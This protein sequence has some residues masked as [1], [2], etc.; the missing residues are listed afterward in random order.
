MA[1][2]EPVKYRRKL[3]ALAQWG[4]T[5]YPK[6][7]LDSSGTVGPWGRW[8]YV[9]GP[10]RLA[11]RCDATTVVTTLRA[12]DGVRRSWD[13]PREALRWLGEQRFRPPGEGPPFKGGWVGWLGYDAGRLF[14][15]MPA[16][17]PDPLG[18]P[19]FEFTFHSELV[20]ADHAEQ[21]AWRIQGNDPYDAPHMQEGATAHPSRDLGPAGQV[22][23]AF[24]RTFSREAYERAVARTVEYVRAGDVFQ[25][26]LSQRF[27]VGTRL[28]AADL[29]AASL[30][31][32]NAWYG[33][34]VGHRDYALVSL[35]PEL[36]FRVTPD[37]A[38]G[39]RTVVTRPIKG[40]RP[41][42]PGMR[43]A[44]AASTKDAAELNM[45]VDLERNDLGRVCRVGTVKVVE[46]RHVERHPTVY[47]GVAG[48][49]G[50]L[51][52]DVTFLDLLRATFPGGSV[53]GAPKIRAMQ[54]ID[55]LEPV[56]RG[57][58]CGAIGYLS[59]DG[60]VQFS[61]AIRTMIVKDGT[62]HLPVGGG[63]VADSQPAAEYEETLVKA[64]AMLTA[65][66]I[67]ER[68]WPE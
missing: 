56:R 52:D 49:E 42:L 23:H 5:Q 13:D 33:A 55:E 1:R 27:S 29:H 34:F 50:V 28:A 58:Y 36:F 16:R 44:L 7:V 41:N 57:P 46:P 48:V 67:P 15:E 20:A 8:S 30:L 3:D 24:G 51:R 37:P 66:G 64:R 35:S 61:V 53:T 45:I 39:D 18:L 63:V 59:T 26:N 25:V 19:L 4:H 9:C 6:V 32:S 14:E 11:L 40:T 10:A 60:H 21:K 65:L 12:A 31:R 68:N 43:D 47:H 38:T 62:V 22:P 54:I 17:S 2:I